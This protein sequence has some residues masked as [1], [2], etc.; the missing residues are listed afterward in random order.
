MDRSPR[1]KLILLGEGGTGKSSFIKRHVTG[2]FEKKYV[3]TFPYEHRFDVKFSTNYGDI[4]FDIWESAGAERF[5]SFR[6]DQ[7]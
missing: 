6:D 2:E 7:A 1:F 4:I 3:V 5:G